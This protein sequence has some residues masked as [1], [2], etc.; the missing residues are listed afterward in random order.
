MLSGM[1]KKRFTDGNSYVRKTSSQRM[2]IT[3]PNNVDLPQFLIFI[4]LGFFLLV[5]I[6]LLLADPNDF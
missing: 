1:N 4:L 3:N 2:P 6:P 5:L